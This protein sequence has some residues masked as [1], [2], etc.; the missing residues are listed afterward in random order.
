VLIFMQ[1]HRATVRRDFDT[2]GF[3]L[4]GCGVGALLFGIDQLGRPALAATVT[5]A[6]I[7]GGALLCALAFLHLRRT[8][9]PVIDLSLFRVSTFA[10]GALTSGNAFRVMVGA[11]PLLWPLLFQVDFGMTAFASGALVIACACGD[12]LMKFFAV[13]VLRRFGFRNT[14]AYN[15][16]LVALAM[17]A[18]VTF[19]AATPVAAIAIVLFVIGVVRSVEFGAF[20]AIIYVDIPPEKMSG[21]TSI[22]GMLQQMSFGTGVAF[23]A[24]VLHFAALHNHG[25]A[26]TYTVADFRAAFVAVSVLGLAGA[27]GFSRLHPHAGA[28]ASGQAVTVSA[29]RQKS[30]NPSP[31]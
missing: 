26:Q 14:L 12:L 2:L 31:G 6:L 7:G 29:R 8:P 23:A 18:C 13:R 4:L 20:N 21:A 17:C 27:Y 25:S 11:M 30:P 1:E 15:G 9:H 16:V 24:L 3:V 19:T 5:A 22:A 10:Q 28:E